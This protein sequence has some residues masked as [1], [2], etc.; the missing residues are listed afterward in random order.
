[1]RQMIRN[2]FDLV[3][4][5]LRKLGAP[6]IRI[7]VTEQ[8]ID[9]R[10][11]DAIDMFLNF[12]MDGSYRQ[13]YVHPITDEDKQRGK[14]ILP[15]TIMSVVNVYMLKD[16]SAT[17]IS[18]SANIQMQSYF[19]DL[20]SKTY[21]ANDISSYAISQSYLGTLTENTGTVRVTTYKIYENELT[22]P[23]VNFS[24]VAVGTLVGLDCFQYKDPDD[25]GKMYNDYWLKQYSTALIKLQWANNIN[26]FATINLPGGGVLNVESLLQEAKLEISELELKLQNEY[27]YPIEPFMY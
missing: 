20:I 13:V 11:N 25:V 2:R 15:D 12:H 16:T 17:G 10:I 24:K 1:M 27:S 18:S 7:N 6:V 26:K 5:C 21:I 23:D 4:Y 14:V 22:I 19:S 8:Q 3:Q 9:D